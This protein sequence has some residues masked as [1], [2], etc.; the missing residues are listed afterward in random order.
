MTE[1]TPEGTSQINYAYDNLYRLTNET[2]AGV[3]PFIASYAYDINS[4]RTQKVETVNGITETIN[5]TYNANDQLLSEVSSI[6]GITV[7]AYDANGSLT[8]KYNTTQNF[9]YAFTYNLQN[10][11]SAA[12]IN[13]QEEGS[14]VTISSD[15][16]YNQEGLRVKADTTVNGVQQARA[17][18]LD[19]GLTGY[20]QVL[21]EL[22]GPGGNVVKSYVIGD[23]VISQTVGGTSHYLLYDGHGS[24]RQLTTDST[25]ITDSYNYDAYGKM[26]GGDPN[27]SHPAATD[28]LYA[29]EQFDVDLQMQYLRARYYDANSGRFNRVDPFEGDNYDPQS[30]HKYAYAHSDPVNNVDPSGK[31]IIGVIA[32]MAIQMS[33]NTWV[34]GT[35]INW[36]SGGALFSGLRLVIDFL[37]ETDTWITAVT[38]VY[39]AMVSV[40]T[41]LTDLGIMLGMILADILTGGISGIFCNIYSAIN[42]AAKAAGLLNDALDSNASKQEIT[43]VLA[44]ALS[45]SLATMVVGIITGVII[46]GIMKYVVPVIGKM[47]MWISDKFNGT[48]SVNRMVIVTSWADEGITP[49]LQSG[50]WVMLGEKTK[51]NYWRS[52][53]P[54]GK[55]LK[56]NK[57]PWFKYEGNQTKFDNSITASIPASQVRWPSGLD[58]IRGLFGQR[59]IK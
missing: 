35:V 30:L 11:L 50:R 44:W 19:S 27:I 2:R 47:F 34:A 32:V 59:I 24:T 14:P 41:N 6:N 25:T 53:L 8:T 28:L 52:G 9:S 38:N 13:R 5:Y 39:M 29:G 37:Q 20:Q 58:R 55:I 43:M 18:L 51:W 57:F 42:S 1:V 21:E 17:F 16:A 33:I 40:L 15:Y 36:A 10:R 12:Q 31:M 4:N 56:S 3:N 48:P 54:G 7:Y 49:D 46:A 22:N 26:V 45:L 23:D